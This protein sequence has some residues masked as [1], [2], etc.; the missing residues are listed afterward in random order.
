LSWR[1]ASPSIHDFGEAINRTVGDG[2]MGS[3]S[4]GAVVILVVE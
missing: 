1:I 4:V 2:A 3:W